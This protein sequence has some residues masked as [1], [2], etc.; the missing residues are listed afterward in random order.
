MPL[1]A[2]RLGCIAGV[3]RAFIFG[4]FAERMAG[5]DGEPVH[6]IDV[7]VIGSPEAEAVY[8]ACR[9]VEDHVH[10]PVNP[11]IMTRQEWAAGSGFITHVA[12]GHTIAIVGGES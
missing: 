2:Q 9:H 7:M 1:L 6:D 10:R 11:T 8:Q 5:I 3:E 4:S 12:G